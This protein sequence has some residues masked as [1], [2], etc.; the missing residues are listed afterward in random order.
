M[1]LGILKRTDAIEVSSKEE[2]MQKNKIVFSGLGKMKS[3]QK[4]EVRVGVSPVAKPPRRIAINLRNQVK[5]KLNELEKKDIIEA[6]KEP[7]E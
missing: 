6:V 5:D 7:A 1:T 3:E 4:L 2:F